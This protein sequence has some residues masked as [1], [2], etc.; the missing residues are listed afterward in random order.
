MDSNETIIE[1]LGHIEQNYNNNE[2][3][4]SEEDSD[5]ECEVDNWYW[6]RYGSWNIWMY[7][8]ILLSN[9]CYVLHF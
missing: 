2:Y 3:D 4:S 9:I 1:N 7:L 8:V 5:T 6:Q